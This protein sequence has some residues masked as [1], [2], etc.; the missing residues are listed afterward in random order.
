MVL[1]FAFLFLG[2]QN[3]EKSLQNDKQ[4]LETISKVST[5]FS[6]GQKPS[7]QEFESL[8]QVFQRYPES[9]TAGQMYKLALIKRE[10]WASL[11]TLLSTTPFENLSLEDRKNLGN[12]SYK[13]GNYQDAVEVLKTLTEE[14]DREVISVLAN[15]YFFLGDYSEAKLLLD[16]NW[17]RI[18]NE[19][20]LNDITLRGLIY[21]RE[22]ESDKAIETLK[23]ALTIAPDNIPAANA[24][25]RIYAARGEQEVAVKYLEQ[26]QRSFDKVT[27]EERRKA[28]VVEK[29]Y[30]LQDAYKAQRFQEVIDIAEEVLP[31]A[32]PKNKL[33]LYQFLYNSHNALGHQKEAQE[34]LENAK[35]FQQK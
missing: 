14:N 15:S 19:K 11:K 10:D 33:T 24:I 27:A 2:C 7:S 8:K 21:F 16:K 4:S 32:D 18:K 34:A 9:Q 28:I 3:D 30:K 29:F 31:E 25:S 6:T 22:N 20:R 12:A 26:V 35:Q 1:A 5:A 23:F 17:E 13:L